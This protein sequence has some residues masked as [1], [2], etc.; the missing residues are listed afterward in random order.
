MNYEEQFERLL[1]SDRRLKQL[2]EIPLPSQENSTFENVD[3]EY[4]PSTV[5]DWDRE[6]SAVVF[7]GECNANYCEDCDDVLHRHA[8]RKSHKRI[9][10]TSPLS[11]PKKTKKRKKTDRCRC[12]T[13]ATKGTLGDPCTGKCFST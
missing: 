4:I 13:G 10:I 3:Q 7:C 2:S 9:P 1:E 6:N 5:C 8:T 11:K 12:G